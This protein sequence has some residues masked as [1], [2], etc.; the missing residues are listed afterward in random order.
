MPFRLSECRIVSILSHPASSAILFIDA[1]SIR[2]SM[3]ERQEAASLRPRFARLTEAADLAGVPRYFA[4]SGRDS[5][6]EDWLSIPCERSRRRV[7]AF[8]SRQAI[9]KQKELLAAL[10]DEMREQ[11]FICGFWL[12]DV[13]SSSA[14]EALAL[15]FNAHIIADLTLAMDMRTRQLVVD[16]LNQ[17]GVPPISLRSLLYEW[18]TNSDDAELK[19]GLSGIWERQ[20]AAERRG[21]SA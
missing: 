20:V 13:V 12:D 14:L 3:L 2:L 17:Y 15:G 11:L 7:F 1:H 21:A 18:M 10:R 6:R 4:M 5:A 16:R 19:C 9:W 8:D